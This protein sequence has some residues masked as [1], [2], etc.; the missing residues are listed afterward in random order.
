MSSNNLE[1]SEY[2]QIL[3]E[4]IRHENELTNHRLGWMSTFNG[5]LFGVVSFLLKDIKHIE[6]IPSVCFVGLAI[7]FSIFLSL[8]A[9]ETV[10]KSLN[11]LW[12]HKH[13]STAEIPPVWGWCVQS[14][15]DRISRLFMPWFLLPFTFIVAW[16]LI[17]IFHKKISVTGV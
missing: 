13:I 10:K 7:D 2:A 9:S 3:R 4:M 5:L 8:C 1:P 6:I 14:T 17:L 12:R 15:K 11:N 16:I